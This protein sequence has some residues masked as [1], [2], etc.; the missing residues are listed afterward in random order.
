MPPVDILQTLR[1]AKPHA[2]RNAAVL[3]HVATPSSQPQ[4][5]RNAPSSSNHRPHRPSH[6]TP[7][8]APS[9]SLPPTPP[10]ISKHV[11]SAIFNSLEKPAS[12]KRANYAYVDNHFE[13]HFLYGLVLPLIARLMA[14]SSPGLLC[15]VQLPRPQVLPSWA[16]SPSY[17]G[18][19]SN[20][21]N[22]S[23]SGVPTIPSPQAT[24][25]TASDANGSERKSISPDGHPQTAE[26]IRRADAVLT[27]VEANH[28][29][30][31][32]AAA[33]AN[34]TDSA[35][36]DPRWEHPPRPVLRSKR[37]RHHGDKQRVQRSDG[38][39]CSGQDDR[40]ASAGADA[41]N[42][43]EDGNENDGDTTES[44]PRNEGQPERRNDTSVDRS[45]PPDPLLQD[46][47]ALRLVCNGFE[48]LT[49]KMPP[50]RTPMGPFTLASV[51]WDKAGVITPEDSNK[52]V[53]MSFSN[54]MMTPTEGIVVT[55]SNG[56]MCVLSLSDPFS[57]LQDMKVTDTTP[58]VVFSFA[59]IGYL[60][61]GD[62]INL[63][64]SALSPSAAA[65]RAWCDKPNV[66]FVEIGHGISPNS[67][68]VD[69][70]PEPE[71]QQPSDDEPAAKTGDVEVTK[72]P[73]CD[74]KSTKRLYQ[75]KGTSNTSGYSGVL[76]SAVPRAVPLFVN[77]I[78]QTLIDGPYHDGAEGGF[79][80]GSEKLDGA[81]AG[82]SGK[83]KKDQ[84]VL[85][86]Q[87]VPTS[88]EDGGQTGIC[89]HDRKS[90]NTG[91]ANIAL[92][93]KESDARPMTVTTQH[94][95]AGVHN[96]A[97]PSPSPMFGYYTYGHHGHLYPPNGPHAAHGHSHGP[98]HGHHSHGHSH[99][100]SHGPGHGHAGAGIVG[101]SVVGHSACGGT[102]MDVHMGRHSGYHYMSDQ[103]GPSS[104]HASYSHGHH[105]SYGHNGYF[106]SVAGHGHREANMVHPHQEHHH[107][108]NGA[109]PHWNAPH[110][111]GDAME[112][113]RDMPV[114]F[115]A[116]GG[117]ASFD[118]RYATSVVPGLS[119]A[120][121]GS[122]WPPHHVESRSGLTNRPS[123][124]NCRPSEVR[125]GVAPVHSGA[126]SSDKEKDSAVALVGMREGESRDWKQKELGRKREKN[127]KRGHSL[128]SNGK[129]NEDFRGS[130][131]ARSGNVAGHGSGG[132]AV[133]IEHGHAKGEKNKKKKINGKTDY[134]NSASFHNQ[135]GPEKRDDHYKR[136]RQR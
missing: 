86:N 13:N 128:I 133:D 114:P 36:N 73:K 81:A 71:C 122:G 96:L 116:H 76:I 60:S 56:S 45:L 22:G 59:P 113:R 10:P 97:A 37:S 69:C 84:C 35:E 109:A 85:A 51:G 30:A 119:A 57:L 108:M 27:D 103:Q 15:L 98:G 20:G 91:D 111:S 31:A 28:C 118:G 39:T 42:E 72:A 123:D 34:A 105:A 17:D 65:V 117:M 82:A 50:P 67:S 129:G 74:G 18:Y 5:N 16:T 80:N 68:D 32:A 58:V 135:G 79:D 6:T 44:P 19:P 53:S 132:A 62:I 120:G 100:V 89:P 64:Q 4:P 24:S 48:V 55:F 104:G 49:G 115:S 121:A 2:M 66:F 25:G 88:G 3:D 7:Q 38:V 43:K 92:P 23:K 40:D 99:S 126:G 90:V 95:M 52:A 46:N 21:S 11:L 61:L 26:L 134:A 107:G 87:T 110:G 70:A 94:G 54:G 47:R 33:A 29:R 131:R 125:H 77:T 124:S 9:S 63:K 112:A 75:R 93:G 14:V 106:H 130:E 136:P 12:N 127:E 102:G 8:A 83:S 1:A 41:D 78:N 101:H